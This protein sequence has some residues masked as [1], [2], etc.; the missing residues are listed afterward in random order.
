MSLKYVDSGIPQNSLQRKYVPNSL[1]KDN[2]L[3]YNRSILRAD[4]V[5]DQ[6]SGSRRSQ[7][8]LF[9]QDQKCAES[10]FFTP[11]PLLLPQF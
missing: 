3:C 1:Y 5:M 11:D 6:I 2:G 8:V 9:C 10:G 4:F 7:N